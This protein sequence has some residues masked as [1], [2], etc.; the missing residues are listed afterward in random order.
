[1]GETKT[2]VLFI[3]RDGQSV[4]R[5]IEESLQKSGSVRI[6]TE[7][8]GKRIDG[9]TAKKAVAKGD[10]QLCIIVPEGTTEAFQ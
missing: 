6:I 8:K 10:F 9:E 4:G 3:D 5:G 7:I 1:M 2:K